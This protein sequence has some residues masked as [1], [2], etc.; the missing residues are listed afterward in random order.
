MDSLKDKFKQTTATSIMTYVLFVVAVV[1][2]DV[3][4]VQL[5]GRVVMG[6]LFALALAGAFALGGSVL[7]LPRKLKNGDIKPGLQRNVAIGVLLAEFAIMAGNVIVAFAEKGG[8]LPDMFLSIYATYVAPVTPVL[9]ALGILLIWL[10]DPQDRARLTAQEAETE[11]KVAEIELQT[12]LATRSITAMKE[13]L[14]TPEAK[15]V[16]QE[17][18]RRQ[19]FDLMY[20]VLQ[21][22]GIGQPQ[23][24]A[25]SPAPI[26]QP[27]FNIM[28]PAQ[29]Q[30]QPLPTIPTIPISTNGHG[31]NA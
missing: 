26:Q 22:S 9:A 18:A 15:A 31:P 7:I 1:F 14:E 25:A 3:M 24:P 8:D 28:P 11:R 6:A 23:P 27:Q 19:G 29:P 13:F 10:A 20:R 12:E 30:P 5:V 17:A 2:A 16:M 21:V 4:Y